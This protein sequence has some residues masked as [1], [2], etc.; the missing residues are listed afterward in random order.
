MISSA[1]NSGYCSY[2]GCSSSNVIA[3]PSE[4]DGVFHQ[5]ETTTGF[6]ILFCLLSFFIVFPLVKSVL[7]CI[8]FKAAFTLAVLSFTIGL[9]VETVGLNTFFSTLLS[10]DGGTL[11]FLAPVVFDNCCFCLLDTATWMGIFLPINGPCLDGITNAFPGG[12]TNFGTV[13]P[14]EL[15]TPVISKAIGVVLD[16]G[17]NRHGQSEVIQARYSSDRFGWCR[18]ECG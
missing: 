6:V 4:V 17:C 7:L 18:K 15:V 9:S 12:F 8:S 1:T 5:V 3:G 14:F 10:A 2:H 11:I 16:G 13:A